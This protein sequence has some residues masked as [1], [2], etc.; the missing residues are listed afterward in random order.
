MAEN[1]LGAWSEARCNQICTSDGNRYFC[2]EFW[3]D[4]W[5][6]GV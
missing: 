3:Y 2:I 6:T 1:R 4:A 5:L